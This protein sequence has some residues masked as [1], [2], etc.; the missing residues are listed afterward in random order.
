MSNIKKINIK[1]DK[2][3]GSKAAEVTYKDNL[4][5]PVPTEVS[6]AVDEINKKL[7][8]ALEK[9]GFKL[10]AP[11]FERYRNREA[12]E[13]KFFVNSMK[14]PFLSL[15]LEKSWWYYTVDAKNIENAKKGVYL[16]WHFDHANNG[17]SNGWT[18]VFDGKS[19]QP[20]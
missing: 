11:I 7:V 14:D 10:D 6:E 3:V 2:K 1:A 13:V 15:A 16:H 5:R 20:E 4:D 9:L 18:F 8:P 17:G 19:I 12:W